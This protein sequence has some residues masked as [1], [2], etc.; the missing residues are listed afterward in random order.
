MNKAGT[1]DEV[2]ACQSGPCG[3]HAVCS[4]TGP[5]TFQCTCYPGYV[6]IGLGNCVDEQQLPRAKKLRALQQESI[7][8]KVKHIEEMIQENGKL[9]DLYLKLDELV[10]RRVHQREVHQN[11]D[12]N[13][14]AHQLESLEHAV[15]VMTSNARTQADLATQIVKSHNVEEDRKRANDELIAKVRGLVSSLIADARESIKPQ[16]P[17]EDTGF[18]PVK[19][20]QIENGVEADESMPQGGVITSAP[21][22]AAPL[23]QDQNPNFPVPPINNQQPQP[24]LPQPPQAQAPPVPQ[25]PQQPQSQPQETEPQP[26]IPQPPS[27]S[28]SSN[29]PAPPAPPQ[30]PQP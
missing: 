12:I 16:P 17:Q 3:G 24:P 15:Q 30:P 25:E 23:P 28:D 14:V 29:I 20:G 13:G 22:D 8:Q 7:E 4:R 18:H 27:P 11:L 19:I 21:V 5:G 2:D 10:N 9:E 6:M 1:C 26:P